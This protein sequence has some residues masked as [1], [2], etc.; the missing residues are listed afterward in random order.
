MVALAFKANYHTAYVER[1]TKLAFRTTYGGS[2][3]FIPNIDPMLNEIY[4]GYGK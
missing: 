4:F 3:S 2:S 1:S